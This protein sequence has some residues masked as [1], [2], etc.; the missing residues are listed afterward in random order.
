MTIRRKLTQEMI[1]ALVAVIVIN[2]IEVMRR[3]LVTLAGLPPEL[4]TT[5][6][7]NG[8]L[9]RRDH[10]VSRDDRKITGAVDR[11]LWW[12]LA[13]VESSRR[14]SVLRETGRHGVGL[15]FVHWVTR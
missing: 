1:T 13:G 8:C 3:G 5:G 2:E 14:L 9:C 10:R 12:L 4:D 7:C 6:V 15:R 11:H